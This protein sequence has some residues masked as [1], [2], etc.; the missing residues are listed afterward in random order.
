MARQPIIRPASCSVLSSGE[1]QGLRSFYGLSS[2]RLVINVYNLSSYPVT[3]YDPNFGVVRADKLTGEHGQLSGVHVVLV[4]EVP[5][6]IRAGL[7]GAGMNE[8]INAAVAEGNVQISGTH[9]SYEYGFHI[10][11]H[12]LLNGV[13]H[14]DPVTG[15][16]IGIGDCDWPRATRG[17]IGSFGGRDSKFRGKLQAIEFVDDHRE[18]IYLAGVKTLEV[19][20]AVP[21]H[22]AGK[23]PGVY[24]TTVGETGEL[25]VKSYTTCE[26]CR[27]EENFAVYERHGEAESFLD[28][29]SMPSGKKAGPTGT[30][31]SMS[32][33]LK[34]RADRFYSNTTQSATPNGRTSNS[35]GAGPSSASAFDRRSRYE[36]VSGDRSW[37]VVIMEFLESVVG[38]VIRKTHKEGFGMWFSEGGT[39]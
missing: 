29:S 9:T 10:K 12:T 18:C 8:L 17:D 26:S 2:V 3:Y 4:L 16:L 14:K 6:N 27:S 20:R 23:Q 36:R 7:I 22:I 5:S 13:I 38:Q 33:R 28:R 21:T 31:R 34:E 24:V 30:A 35:A 11:D 37:L 1:I 32:E 25:E 15:I 39:K 19:I